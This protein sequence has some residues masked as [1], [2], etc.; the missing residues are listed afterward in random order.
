MHFLLKLIFHYVFYNF[1]EN[2]AMKRLLFFISA[3]CISILVTGQEP[4]TLSYQAIVHNLNGKIISSKPVT[5]RFSILSVS[6]KD[7]VVFSEITKAATD[8]KGAVSLSIG[9]GDNQTGSISDIDWNIDR[10]LLKV[11]LDTAGGNNFIE[12]GTTQILA[13]PVPSASSKKNTTKVTE[14]KLFLSRKYAGKFLDFRQTGPKTNGSQNIVWIKT[15]MESTFGKI[16]A[17]GKKCTFKVGENLYIKRTYY[18]PGG[19]SGYWVYQIENNSGVF[20]RL[21]DIQYDKKVGVETFFK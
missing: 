2:K 4:E 11:E 5:F 10:Y 12:I 7:S 15:S 20:Y 17:I 9:N 1:S 21:S 6:E 19:V 14:D 16:S 3:F 8:N 13:V 18:N